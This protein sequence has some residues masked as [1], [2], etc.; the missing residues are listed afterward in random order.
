[1]ISAPKRI[2]PYAR[3]ST[4]RQGRSGLGLE[5]QVRDIE[6]LVASRG[7][8]IAHP[9]FVDVESGSKDDRSGLQDALA[10]CRDTGAAL[11]VAKLDRLSRD[12]AFGA[13]LL[14]EAEREGVRIVSAD[15]PEADTLMLHIRLAV[16]EEERRMVSRRTKAALESAK[17]RG[18]K[19]GGRRE[20]A[21]CFSDADRA[22]AGAARA[23]ALARKAKRAAS[24]YRGIVDELRAAGVASN[25]A[26]A[27]AL[28][29]RGISSPRGGK[30]Q[31]TTVGRLLARLT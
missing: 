9:P 28:N 19:L 30:W 1:M 23:T 27:S 17:A 29:E 31:A 16:A 24:Q 3:V 15:M 22:R 13:T 4:E 10:L 5:A 8:L 6:G 21:H 2:I 20:G 18:V 25:T 14:K 12:V 11:V 26:L 7:W